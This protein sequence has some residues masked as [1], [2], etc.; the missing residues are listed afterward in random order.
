MN[1]WPLMVIT[2][3]S[4][5]SLRKEPAPHLPKK[6]RQRLEPLDKGKTLQSDFYWEKGTIV[7]I[8]V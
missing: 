6:N 2:T 7:D 4:E 1:N 3:P 5:M 8:Y